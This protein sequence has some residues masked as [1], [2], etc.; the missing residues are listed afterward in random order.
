M[1]LSGTQHVKNTVN[2][3]Y[4]N[5]QVNVCGNIRAK[6]YFWYILYSVDSSFPNFVHMLEEFLSIASWME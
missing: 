1:Q 3:Q 6:H 5:T 4:N 2:C